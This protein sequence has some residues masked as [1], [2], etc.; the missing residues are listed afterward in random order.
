M[1]TKKKSVKAKKA[2]AAK[3]AAS[4][5]VI[6]QLS[7][8]NAKKAIEHYKKAFGAVEEHVL[9]CPVTGTVAHAGIKIGDTGIFLTEENPERGCMS[10]S[11]QSFY[12]YVPD[13]DAAMKKAV[14]A[15]LAETQ[16]AQDTFWGDRMGMVTDPYGITWCIATH[17]RNVSPKEMQ[18]AMKKMSECAA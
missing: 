3:H 10:S 7:L 11:G 18:V 4:V 6:P 5:R 16:K 14:K 15:G 2:A 12:I 8:K 1:P 13:A 9:L 17:V